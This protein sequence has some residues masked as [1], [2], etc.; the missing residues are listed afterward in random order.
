MVM[1]ASQVITLVINLK[2]IPT[3]TND[4]RCGA[5]NSLE[6][7]VR[8]FQN[9]RFFTITS[10]FCQKPFGCPFSKRISVYCNSSYRLLG[11]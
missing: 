9:S 2:L 5:A 6:W 11:G 10:D 8:T 3:L 1:V 4:T 7:I